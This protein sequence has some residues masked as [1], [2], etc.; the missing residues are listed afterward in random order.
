MLE[1]LSAFSLSLKVA[2]VGTVLGAPPGILLARLL[3]RGR[4]KAR[5]AVEAVVSLPLVLP[6]VLT[7]YFLLLLF[8]RNGL[9][10][11]LLESLGISIAFDW[12][13]A[14]V[15]AAVMGFPLLV[16][17][18][19]VGFESVDPEIEQTAR[20]LGAG[21]WDTFV[22]VTLP[23]ARR[24]ILAGL[25]LAFAR[26]LGEF[27]ATIVLAGNIAGQTRTIPLA[28]YRWVQT[29]GGGAQALALG[30]VSAL[31]GLAALLVASRMEPQR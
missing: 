25:V 28:I 24:G 23:L 26:S 11:G 30:G 18:A 20:S 16:R 19:R 27:G 15:V 17:S 31:L 5:S 22:H 21:P 7:G 9:L 10:G 3:S 8:G 29:P 2:L 4:F 12:K 13:G 1:G 14:A 6:P